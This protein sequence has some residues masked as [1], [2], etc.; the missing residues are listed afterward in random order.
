MYSTDL[1][2]NEIIESSNQ[3]DMIHRAKLVGHLTQAAPLPREYF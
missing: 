1:T 3:A 2:N